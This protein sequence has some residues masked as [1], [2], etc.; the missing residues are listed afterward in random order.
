MCK[1]LFL[2]AAVLF[3]AVANAQQSSSSVP[4]SDSANPLGTN[5]SIDCSDPLM[6]GSSLCASDLNSA[7]LRGGFSPSATSRTPSPQQNP[8][9]TYNDDTGRS[10]SSSGGS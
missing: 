4:G 8:I 3:A 6:A 9:T 1:R 5:N 7:T 10:A 2:I